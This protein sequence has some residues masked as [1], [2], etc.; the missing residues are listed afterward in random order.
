MGR[1]LFF[2]LYLQILLLGSNDIVWKIKLGERI[3]ASPA[4]YCDGTIYIGVS[5]SSSN[6]FGELFAIDM[7]G[8]IKWR[9]KFD[10][11]INRS[12]ALGKDGI[13]YLVCWDTLYAFT[14]NGKEKWHYTLST[15]GTMDYS[16]PVVTNT[17][18]YLCDSRNV[19]HAF[20]LRGN[21]VWSKRLFD[22]KHGTGI[23]STPAIGKDGTIYIRGCYSLFAI[24]PDGQERWKYTFGNDY[25]SYRGYS[26]P[27]IGRDGTI[28]VGVGNGYVYAIDS[29][30]NL[31]WRYRTGEH[32]NAEIVL[33]E[34][35]N[36]YF[37]SGRHIVSLTSTG[38]LRWS[39]EGVMSGSAPLVG[40][41]Y[42]YSTMGNYSFFIF[43]K[44]GNVNSKILAGSSLGSSPTLLPNG[45]VV[46]G[47]GDGYLYGIDV[48]AKY[49]Y[50][51]W[52]K[53]AHDIYNSANEKT[54]SFLKGLVGKSY[55]TEGY[56]IHYG[57]G[58]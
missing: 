21:E 33:D 35:E 46:Y 2:I 24:T 3:L 54:F 17:R 28:Y 13:I 12:V 42:I 25:W 32:G 31:K 51:S 23:Y 15:I 50:S 19:L 8:H 1:F 9:K 5:N 16:T 18:V 6:V 41:N 39:H 29:N 47:S 30:G 26:S 43:D 27:A 11:P 14:R 44:N 20:D 53:F 38:I 40:R 10:H 55:R 52:P 34:N 49:S 36:L 56:F 57:Q 22:T 45:I 7:N 58:A 4:V 37:Q 48:N